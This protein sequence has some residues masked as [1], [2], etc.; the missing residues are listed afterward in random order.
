MI[1]AIRTRWKRSCEVRFTLIAEFDDVGQG[2]RSCGSQTTELV[3]RLTALEQGVR[4]RDAGCDLNK[5][6]RQ[7]VA[8]PV[9]HRERHEDREYEQ[10][11]EMLARVKEFNEDVDKLLSEYKQELIR[12]KNRK[13]L[14]GLFR[15]CIRLCL[16][17]GRECCV[18]GNQDQTHD[19]S[20]AE[21]RQPQLQQDARTDCPHQYCSERSVKTK[22]FYWWQLEECHVRIKS[23]EARVMQLELLR[24]LPLR[25][26]PR[27][28]RA[29][30]QTRPEQ[31]KSLHQTQ[32]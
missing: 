22:Q 11:S 10:H 26:L 29:P 32:S 25:T 3:A 5:L 28:S 2:A 23:W 6:P 31:V 19:P 16:H 12:S 13:L 20:P 14:R 17:A 8:Q 27:R 30:A 4:E 15:V 18:M 24:K 9:W 7:L 21:H 1:R